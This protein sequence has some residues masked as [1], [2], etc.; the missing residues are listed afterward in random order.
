MFNGKYSKTRKAYLFHFPW[1]IWEQE[2][3]WSIYRQSN[4]GI[5]S[6]NQTPWATGSYPKCHFYIEMNSNVSC[7][8]Y[9]MCLEGY[10][11][12]FSTGFYCSTSLSLRD[13]RK[14][15]QNE[16][17]TEPLLLDLS[18]IRDRIYKAI[19]ANSKPSK[20]F[21]AHVS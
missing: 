8:I 5:L 4:T 14:A 7:F 15:W 12:A 20:Q 2:P 3:F 9:E 21:I 6:G 11:L 1:L 16:T 13:D 17:K 18:N 19:L 10:Y